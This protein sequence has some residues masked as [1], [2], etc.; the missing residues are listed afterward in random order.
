MNATK[1]RKRY[2]AWAV[3]TGASDG[4]GYAFAEHLAAMSVNLVLVARNAERLRE[5][6][7]ALRQKHGVEVL[8]L[9]ADLSTGA[10]LAEV[11][12]ATAEL[13]VG[14]YVACAGFGTSGLLI[15]A[16]LDRERSMIEV[17]CHAVMH[18]CV[19]FGRRFAVQRRGGIILLGS[20]VGWQ[21][22]PRSA[23]YAATKA[24]VQSLAEAL[25]V[26]LAPFKV[27]VL[28]SAPGPVHTGFAKVADMRMGAAVLPSVVADVSLRALGSRGTV[29]PGALSKFLTLSLA[30]LPRFLRTRILG[31]VMGS[32]TKHQPPGSLAAHSS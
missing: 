10:G 24:Y 14:L 16:D 6:A 12:R 20:L 30:F 4:I 32:M 7:T 23:H 1:F 15:D 26:E 9:A 5:L 2:G 17:N 18:G 8:P 3:V 11:D 22:T 25:R 28:C 31:R 13:N 27:D 21:G 29:V 19:Q